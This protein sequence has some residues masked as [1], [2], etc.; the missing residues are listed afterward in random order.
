MS[1]QE[2][3]EPGFFE[4][5]MYWVVDIY[6]RWWICTRGNSPMLAEIGPRLEPP[7]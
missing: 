3:I 2:T 7:K 5:M 1:E 4:P 6:G